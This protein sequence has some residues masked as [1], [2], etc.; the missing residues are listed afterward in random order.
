MPSPS[1]ILGALVG[2]ALIMLLYSQSHQNAN[3]TIKNT[4]KIKE[5]QNE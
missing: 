2:V 3:L 1:L 5:K 4:F